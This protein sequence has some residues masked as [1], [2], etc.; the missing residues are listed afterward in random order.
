MASHK[1]HEKNSKHY[2][3]KYKR[4]CNFLLALIVDVFTSFPPIYSCK[5]KSRSF[6][7]FSCVIASLTF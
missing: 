5:R 1:C 3:I 4:G 7:N 2:M 6:A